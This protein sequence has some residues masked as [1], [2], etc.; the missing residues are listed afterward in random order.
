[1]KANKKIRSLRN[2][3]GMIHIP[4]L[5]SLTIPFLF[6]IFI[7]IANVFVDV[8]GWLLEPIVQIAILFTGAVIAVLGLSFGLLPLFMLLM[9]LWG[10]TIYYYAQYI[11]G[12]I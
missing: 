8:P 6:I 7:H 1:M 3:V 4:R 9:V 5:L 2:D 12:W 10:I 11:G